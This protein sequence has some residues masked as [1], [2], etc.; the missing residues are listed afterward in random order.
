MVSQLGDHP[1]FF[2][3][4][5]DEIKLCTEVEQVIYSFDKSTSIF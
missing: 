2:K 3:A 5:I 1:L 4:N